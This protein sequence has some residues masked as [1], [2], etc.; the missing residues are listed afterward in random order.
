[1]ATPNNARSKRGALCLGGFADRPCARPPE[2]KARAR[3]QVSTPS[4]YARCGRLCHGHRYACGPLLVPKQAAACQ[5]D[6][7]PPLSRLCHAKPGGLPIELRPKREAPCLGGFAAENRDRHSGAATGR[8]LGSRVCF[9]SLKTAPRFYTARA[10]Y[11][12]WIRGKRP[13]LS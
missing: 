9:L 1:M 12:I 13:R 4:R 8:H 2:L 6:R 5:R 10:N 3:A 7:R 11:H